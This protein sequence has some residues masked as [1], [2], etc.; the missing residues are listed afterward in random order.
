[1]VNNGKKVTHK[2]KLTNLSIPIDRLDL[3]LYCN[4][5]CFML[6]KLR[7]VTPSA[8]SLA[9]LNLLVK[10]L[11]AVNNVS[12]WDVCVTWKFVFVWNAGPTSCKQKI[13]LQTSIAW[14]ESTSVNYDFIIHAVFN[15]F[16]IQCFFASQKSYCFVKE[17]ST[18]LMVLI[19]T[20]CY[21]VFTRLHYVT[22]INNDSTSGWNHDELRQSLSTKSYWTSTDISFY[23]IAKRMA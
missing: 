14:R 18:P 6:I 19:I 4:F 7:N 22:S 9:L 1:M 8:D 15:L 11:P 20:I 3:S 12:Y 21:N 23:I 17:N 10:C 13:Q 16:M 2:K 5:K